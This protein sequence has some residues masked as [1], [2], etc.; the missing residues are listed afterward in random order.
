[1]SEP[2]YAWDNHTK[3]FI[4]ENGEPVSDREVQDARTEYLQYHQQELD[5][6]WNQLASGI[7]SLQTWYEQAKHHIKIARLAL[8]ALEAG[9]FQQLE[10]MGYKEVEEQVAKD[11][12]GLRSFA[13]IVSQRQDLPKIGLSLEELLFSTIPDLIPSTKRSSPLPLHLKQPTFIEARATATAL[14][15]GPDLRNWKPITGAL[16]LLHDREGASHQIRFEPSSLLLGWWNKDNGPVELSNLEAEL[17]SLELDAI[18]TFFICLASAIENPDLDTSIDEIIAAIGRDKDARRTSATRTEWRGKVWRWLLIFDSLLVIGARNRGTWREPKNADQKRPPME[19]QRLYT[20]DALLKIIGQS[21]TEQG[22]LDN[23]AVPKEVSLVL[24]PWAREFRGNR[25]ILSEFGTLRAI[26]TIPR[27]KPSGAWA[28]CAGL[29][30]QQRWREKASYA[31]VVRTGE[32]KD[33]ITQQFR[34]VTRKELLLETWRSGNS[35]QKI[36]ESP[37]PQRAK[38]YWDQAVGILKEHGIIGY[39]KELK[40][41][42]KG[43]DWQDEWLKQPLDIRPAGDTRND[44]VEIHASAQ[45]AKKRGRKKKMA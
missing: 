25:E 2:T 21:G 11:Y 37:N 9:G 41:L 45:A 27:G 30:L 23:S 12:T 42:R 40:P 34:P 26:A 20:K 7:I 18:I 32:A 36:L 33:Q 14:C 15:D 5:D 6:L 38:A 24:G 39:Y 19:A 35:L 28:A 16:A 8:S 1:M 44:A 13:E 10:V 4:R 31:P 17:S 22:T 29:M 43:Y 3:Q